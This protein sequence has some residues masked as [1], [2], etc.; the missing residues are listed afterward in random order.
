MEVSEEKCELTMQYMKR[1]QEEKQKKNEEEKAEA[2]HA[3]LLKQKKNEEEEAAAVDPAAKQ[4]Y[5]CQ[6]CRWTAE[7]C[8]YCNPMKHE[9]WSQ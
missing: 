5:G 4:F 1:K 3:P 6:R 9:E 8:C 2:V 7:G